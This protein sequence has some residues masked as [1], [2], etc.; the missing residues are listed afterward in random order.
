[1]PRRDVGA[2]TGPLHLRRG[3]VPPAARVARADQR[4]KT[5][6]RLGPSSASPSHGGRERPC[7]MTVRSCASAV[8]RLCVSCHSSYLQQRR[9][10]PNEVAHDTRG[11]GS[12]ASGGYGTARHALEVCLAA[13]GSLL[14]ALEGVADRGNR[15]A[16]RECELAAAVP[17]DGLRRPRRLRARLLHLGHTPQNGV[18]R[19]R[20]HPRAQRRGALTHGHGDQCRVGR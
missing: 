20:P 3:G 5:G 10:R 11:D 19:A 13:R 16:R 6:M 18:T 8:A 4:V 9:A 7:T 1:M 2:R 14:R 15:A 17:K 12:G